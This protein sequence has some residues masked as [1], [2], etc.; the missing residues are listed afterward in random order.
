[1]DGKRQVTLILSTGALA[2][3]KAIA[4]S[5]CRSQRGQAAY[6]LEKLLR[7]QGIAKV[8]LDAAEQEY[9]RPITPEPPAKKV[10][11]LDDGW[12]A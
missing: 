2:V 8:A 12:G 6:M 4:D 9:H 10:M 7:S 5:E 11:L 3:L 1:M